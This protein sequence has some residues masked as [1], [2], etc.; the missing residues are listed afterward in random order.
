MKSS[1]APPERKSQLGRKRNKP[2]PHVPTELPTEESMCKRSV[3]LSLPASF[4]ISFEN[5]CGA[6]VWSPSEVRHPLVWQN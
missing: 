5:K 6:F 3:K 2:H 4:L 1:L